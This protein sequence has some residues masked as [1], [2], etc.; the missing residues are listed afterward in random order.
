LSLLLLLALLLPPPPPPSSSRC[1]CC[2]WYNQHWYTLHHRHH[3]LGHVSPS[4][5]VNVIAREHCACKARFGD[6]NHSNHRW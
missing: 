4:P 3:P 6:S 1:R 2:S 5:G